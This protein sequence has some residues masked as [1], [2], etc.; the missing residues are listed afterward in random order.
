MHEG[1]ER[2]ISFT[3][4]Y[5][6]EKVN[7]MESH[8]LHA[9]DRNKKRSYCLWNVILTDFLQKKS[10]LFVYWDRFKQTVYFLLKTQVIVSTFPRQINEKGVKMKLTEAK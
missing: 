10:V 4:T 8:E 9:A 1:T 3:H 6:L 5:M 7:N 2:I